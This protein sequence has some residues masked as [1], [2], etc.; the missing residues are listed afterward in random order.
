[1]PVTC[2]QTDLQQKTCTLVREG[3][4]S[5]LKIARI[6]VRHVLLWGRVLT[7]PAVGVERPVHEDLGVSLGYYEGLADAACES[8]F[9]HKTVHSK[10]Y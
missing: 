9:L 1:M 8:C 7:P 5:V 10:L 3:E 2:I 6:D 4:S